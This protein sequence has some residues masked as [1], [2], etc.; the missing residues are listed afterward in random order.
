MSYK[1]LFIFIILISVL[2][3]FSLIYWWNQTSEDNRMNEVSWGIVNQT[4]GAITY[5]GLDGERA[6]SLVVTSDGGFALA[7]HTKTLGAGL[8][9]FWL[10]KTDK[11]GNM[12]W[13]QNYGGEERDIAH[14]LIETSDGGYAL[15]GKILYY[16]NVSRRSNI[17]LVKTDSLGVMEWS[18]TYGG[19][20]SDD[21]SSL[22]EASDGGYVFAGATQF[23]GSGNGYAWLVKTDSLG[24]MEWNQTYGGLDNDRVHSLI[25]TSDGG[26][27]LGLQRDMIETIPH[28]DTDVVLIETDS[29]GVME[30][31]QTYGG[32]ERDMVS[33]LVEVSDG[34]F[35]LAATTYSFG[36]GGGD[37]WLVKTDS[38]GVMEWNQTYGG[39]EDNDV[40]SL[41][42]VSDGGYVLAGMRD[43]SD[44]GNDDFWLIKTDGS[45]N[46]N[47]SRSYGGSDIDRANSLV[48]ISD[49]DFVIAGYTR[50][51]GAGDDD[52]FLV[53]TNIENIPEI[54]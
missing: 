6:N 37:F 40:R 30:W 19:E 10:V 22:V 52:V 9:D 41:V 27:A 51:F 48:E 38:L 2:L 50:S 54:P 13:N 35:A 20:F 29:L 24:V 5:G 45:G 44:Y 53:R 12:E 42:E 17:W 1:K 16:S 28:M 34:G 32:A 46:L 4:Y 11:Q 49:G 8:S 3:S 47:W 23:S 43:E 39:I 26:Y 31:N 25:K 21:V 14:S 15:I 33:S 7:G 18:Q 36:V